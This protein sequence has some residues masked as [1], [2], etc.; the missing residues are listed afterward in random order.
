MTFMTHLTWI[1]ISKGLDR[2]L[3]LN[4]GLATPKL[5]TPNFGSFT[6]TNSLTIIV[7]YLMEVIIR[8]WIPSLV[9]MFHFCLELAL[10]V[11]SKL[12]GHILHPLVASGPPSRDSLAEPDSHTK[13]GRESGDTRILSWC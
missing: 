3:R 10:E 12:Y 4:T 13:I 5:L 9:R 11:E 6:N 7:G 8:L 1:T 2:G